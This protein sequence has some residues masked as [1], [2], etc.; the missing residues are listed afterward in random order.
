MSNEGLLLYPADTD[1]PASAYASWAATATAITATPTAGLQANGWASDDLV[2]V[3]EI[4]GAMKSTQDWMQFVYD[5]NQA[6]GG[7]GLHAEYFGSGVDGDVTIS[8]PTT[9]TRDM[10]YGQ[11]TIDSGGYIDTAGYRIYAYGVDLSTA[12]AGAIRF[13]GNNGAAPIGN[14][15]VDVAGGLGG[16]AIVGNLLSVS[17]GKGGDSI[18]DAFPADTPALATT[19]RAH[20]A[21]YVTQSEVRK[22]G[23]GGGARPALF[24]YPTLSRYTGSQG[25]N[26]Y[27]GEIQHLPLVDHAAGSFRSKYIG[28]GLGGGGGGAGTANIEGSGAGGGGGGGGASGGF[29][30]IGARYITIDPAQPAGTIQA[31]GGDGADGSF[32]FGACGGGA[33]GGGGSGGTVVIVCEAVYLN[34]GDNLSQGVAD[35]IDV[36]GGDGGDGSIASGT[37]YYAG[38]GGD[39]GNGGV[40]LIIRTGIDPDNTLGIERMTW[41]PS[42]AMGADGEQVN[43]GSTENVVKAG[44]AGGVWKV[45]L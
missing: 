39:G 40:V 36:S 16:A 13:N 6:A 32:G 44:G 14:Q 25:G 9:L 33:G 43:Y 5:T 3:D 26:N 42:T 35:V 24:Y 21:S 31:L 4:N 1:F 18:D 11:L 38:C 10:F 15:P 41:A 17:G 37:N 27:N 19:P 22:G 8:A 28:G 45:A 29:I 7:V 12:D 2:R 30:F 20:F 23:D 34:T